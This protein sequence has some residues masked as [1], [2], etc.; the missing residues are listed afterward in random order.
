[1]IVP[2]SSLDNPL[3]LSTL[4]TLLLMI[5]TV[6]IAA[7]GYVI[8]DIKDIDTDR[9]NKSEKQ[10]IGRGISTKHGWI[11]YFTLVITGAIC[12]LTVAL[13][14]N[15]PFLFLIYPLATLLLYLYSYAFKRMALIGNIV[16]SAFT[17]G[18]PFILWYAESDMYFGLNKGDKTLFLF[19]MMSFIV[20]AFLLNMIREL[21]K[22]IEDMEGDRFVGLSTFPLIFGLDKSKTLVLILNLMAIVGISV[23][24]SQEIYTIVIRIIISVLI[25]LPLFYTFLISY[26]L[27]RSSE[28][29]ILSNYYKLIMAAGMILFVF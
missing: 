3:E 21:I 16:V 7:A 27:T 24:L 17:A 4:M 26:K 9:I 18:V 11:W 10:W 13:S 29:H 22:D 23:V 14:I 19:K 8:N 6:L 20:F 2:Y 12:S 5:T 25:L 15:K 28:C 1:M